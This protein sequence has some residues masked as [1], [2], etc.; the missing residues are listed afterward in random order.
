MKYHK[1]GGFLVR[2]ADP[3]RAGAS[4]RSEIADELALRWLPS[5]WMRRG[6]SSSR[7]FNA[8]N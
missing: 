5:R 7:W 1:H 2:S 3:V 4:A 8:S 6:L